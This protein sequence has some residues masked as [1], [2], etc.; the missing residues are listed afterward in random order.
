MRRRREECQ[1]RGI[2]EKVTTMGNWGSMSLGT[3]GRWCTHASHVS[4]SR[5]KKLGSYPIIICHSLKNATWCLN[6]LALAAFPMMTKPIRE[7]PQ[8]HQSRQP[9]GR[10]GVPRECGQY[11]L[12]SPSALHS[13][14][15]VYHSCSPFFYPMPHLFPSFR[16][17]VETII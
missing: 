11:L 2:N 12:D 6:I 14:Y 9:S 17:K 3:S 1:Y 15:S 4:H 13:S 5:V 10:M 7:S 16:N 8:L